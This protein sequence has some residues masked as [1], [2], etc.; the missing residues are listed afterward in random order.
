MLKLQ[1]S[2]LVFIAKLDLKI[3]LTARLGNLEDS[4]DDKRYWRC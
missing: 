4:Q 2:D 3:K 1:K